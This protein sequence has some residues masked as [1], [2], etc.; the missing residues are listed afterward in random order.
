[1][2][3][4]LLSDQLGHP[5]EKGRS[6]DDSGSFTSWKFFENANQGIDPS[7]SGCLHQGLAACSGGDSH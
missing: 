4:T 5:P 2:G 6:C 7:A 3:E 1:V